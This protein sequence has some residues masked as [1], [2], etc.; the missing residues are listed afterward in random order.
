VILD[1][2]DVTPAQFA[3]GTG[4]EIK[5]GGACKADVCVSRD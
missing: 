5:P 3:A 4:W 2:L 1:S